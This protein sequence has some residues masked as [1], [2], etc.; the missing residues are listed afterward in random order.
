MLILI[1]FS[2]LALIG[3][4]IFSRLGFWLFTGFF[5]ASQFWMILFLP[6]IHLYNGQQGKPVKKFFYIY[7]PLHIYVLMLLGQWIS[8]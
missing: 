1:V 3:A 4:Q 7:Y 8:I 6:L 5:H 2:C